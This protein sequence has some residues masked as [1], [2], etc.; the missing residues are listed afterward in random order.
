MIYG[1]GCDV[2]DIDR[3]AAKLAAHPGLLPRL[4]TPA[5]QHL[6]P[7][8]LAARFAAKEAAIKA[9]GGSTI[10]NQNDSYDLSWQDLEVLPAQGQRPQFTA[11]W[12]LQRALHL[13]AVTRLHLSLS[14]DGNIAQAYVVA[15]RSEE[16]Q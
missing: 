8:S 3:F 4:F 5:E 12:G 1:I 6:P 16:G 14:H 11:T 7:R 10:K 15:E 13:S 9:L 2:V